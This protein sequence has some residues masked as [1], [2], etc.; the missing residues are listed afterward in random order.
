MP[1]GNKNIRP[2]DGKQFSSTYQPDEKWTE[3]KALD[4]GK[5][6]IKWQKETDEEGKDKGNIFWEEFFVIE[7]NYYPE[8]PTYLA[9]KFLSFS[10]LLERA[11]KIQEIKLVKYGVADRLNASMTKFCLTNHHGYRDSQHIDHTTQGQ[12]VNDIQ[13]TVADKATID[14]VKKLMNG[15]KPNDDI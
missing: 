12:A 2:E 10:K 3:K 5:E 11:K 9:G 8:L 15:D 7:N 4:L 14:K 1:G 6:L 13:I